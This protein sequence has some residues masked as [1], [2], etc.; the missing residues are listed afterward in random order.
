MEDRTS[1][2]ALAHFCSAMV[3]LLLLACAFVLACSARGAL[4][5][6][7]NRFLSTTGAAEAHGAALSGGEGQ[8]LAPSIIGTIGWCESSYAAPIKEVRFNPR[9]LVNEESGIAISRANSGV[10]W[11]HNDNF[12]PKHIY[13]ILAGS[14]NDPEYDSPALPP[15]S[16]FS[17]SL[18]LSLSFFS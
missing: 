2:A 10:V 17:P 13:G 11:V 7:V 4:A 14:K 16:P 15:S 18:V 9:G 1:S 3:R 12:S 8:P 6:S 5:V